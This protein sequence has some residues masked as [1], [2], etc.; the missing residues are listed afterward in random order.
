MSQKRALIT[1]ITGMDGSHLAELL[2]EKGYEVHGL[3]RRH[4]VEKD[5]YERIEHIQDQITLHTGDLL[6][7]TGIFSVVQQ[8]QPD[9]LYS[10]AAQSHV[11]QSSNMPIFTTR[12][13]AVG[14]VTLLEALKQNKPHDKK[15]IVSTVHKSRHPIHRALNKTG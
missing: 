10:L 4:S 11:G 6:D 12:V 14:V 1:G 2:L 9:E 7:E 5:K 8:V 13:D 15:R 3:V